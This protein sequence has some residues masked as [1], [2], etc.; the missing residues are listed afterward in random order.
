[1]KPGPDLPGGVIPGL[2]LLSLD[3]HRPVCESGAGLRRSQGSLWLMLPGPAQA[4]SAGPH[5]DAAAGGG[6]AQWAQPRP[7]QDK[8][9]WQSEREIFSTPGMRHENLLQ[10][11]AAEKRGSNLEVELWLI[12]AF[13]DKVSCTL[14]AE[15]SS[16]RQGATPAVPGG[17]S[18]WDSQPSAWVGASA[19]A[20]PNPAV[21][22]SQGGD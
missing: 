21:T 3:L 4:R 18:T 8:Q 19:V 12:T 6:R 10:F 17:L 20:T 22:R 15:V 2:P 13:H 14:W 1:M 9:S 11:I 16:R 5:S 7:P